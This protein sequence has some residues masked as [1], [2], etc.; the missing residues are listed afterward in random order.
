MVLVSYPQ[1]IGVRA[2]LG[3]TINKRNGH[4]YYKGWPIKNNYKGKI[5]LPEGWNLPFVD[6]GHPDYMKVCDIIF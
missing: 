3:S 1:N 2:E 4:H 6:N 5:L